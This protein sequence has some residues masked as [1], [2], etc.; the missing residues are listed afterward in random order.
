MKSK[1]KSS[2]KW[3]RPGDGNFQ[4]PPDDIQAFEV[5]PRQ[6]E[7]IWWRKPRK[8]TVLSTLRHNHED[9][10]GELGTRKMASNL[11]LDR[12]TSSSADVA[13]QLG[14]YSEDMANCN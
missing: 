10:E 8:I 2:R 14:D 9:H 3:N 13:I 6:L 1:H 5:K 12:R 4:S 11:L 7:P